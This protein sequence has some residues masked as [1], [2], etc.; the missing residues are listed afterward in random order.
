MSG[1]AGVGGG[2]WWGVGR[3]VGENGERGGN[4]RAVGWDRGAEAEG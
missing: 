4:L 1:C 2:G 3:L